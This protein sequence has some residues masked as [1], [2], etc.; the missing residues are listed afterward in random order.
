MAS[1]GTRG[2]AAGAPSR[3]EG[4]PTSVH[5]Q[6]VW[7]DEE[8]PMTMQ[9]GMVGSDGVLIASDILRTDS[10]RIGPQEKLYRPRQSFGGDTKIL[11]DEKRGIVV[12]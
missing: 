4:I 5:G 9:V 11:A 8:F 2:H 1:V 7:S 6:P 3:N 12:S 10:L